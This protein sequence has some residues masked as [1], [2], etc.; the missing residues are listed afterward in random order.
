M[1]SIFEKRKR[2][3]RIKILKSYVPF[4]FDMKLNHLTLK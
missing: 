4:G 2:K 3:Q 1:K